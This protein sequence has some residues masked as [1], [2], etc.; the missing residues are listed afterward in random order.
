MYRIYLLLSLSFLVGCANTA[1]R[2]SPEEWLNMVSQQQV[3]SVISSCHGTHQNF[4]D[5]KSPVDCE[6]YYP[7]HLKMSFP[8]RALYV[9]HEIGVGEYLNMWCTATGNRAGRLPAIQ[10]EIREEGR[11]FGIP[12]EHL[13]NRVREYK[14]REQELQQGDRRS[15]LDLPWSHD[16]QSP[17]RTEAA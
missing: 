4:V 12:C 14:R 16:P 6:V 5:G 15:S 8:T 13:M 1:P 17:A 7:A 11:M 9:E 3:D 2:Q 10:L